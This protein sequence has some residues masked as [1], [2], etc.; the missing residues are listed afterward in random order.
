[1]VRRLLASV[2][3][4]ALSVALLASNEAA[5]ANACKKDC[6]TKRKQAFSE[7]N[8]TKKACIAAAP[9]GKAGKQQRRDCKVAWRAAKKTAKQ[10]FNPKT[11]GCKGNP[12]GTCGGTTTTTIPAPTTCT[13]TPGN[14]VELDFTV[15][16]TGSD[17]D[18]GYTGNSHNFPVVHGSTLSYCLSNC[19]ASADSTC[20]AAGATGAGTPNTAFFG[21]PLPLLSAGVPVCV[22][23]EFVD[24]TVTGTVDLATGVMSTDVKLTSKVYVRPGNFVTVCP[25]CS[26]DGTLGSTGKCQ[27][28]SNDGKACKVNGLV[29][30]SGSN[31][32]DYQVSSD[33]PPEGTGIPLSIDLPLTTDTSQKT[34]SLP[35][36]AEVGQSQDDSCAPG[37]TCSVD[38]S[39]IQDSKGGL[40]QLCCTNPANRPCFPTKS[41]PGIVRMGNPSIPQPAWPDPTYP[42]TTPAG[43]DSKMVATFCIP[44]TNDATV[45]GLTGLPGPG[46]IILPG[47]VTVKSAQ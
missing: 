29:T 33:C 18:N 19:D 21:A 16:A 15:P 5:A 30:V 24:P 41:G 37:A 44:K 13:G 9:K 20:D 2:P 39:G 31:P 6:N 47:E 3:V 32:P 11:A 17:L 14:P 35:C 42:K 27:G 10:Q 1:M 40:N 23:N 45:D 38:C 36:K 12:T 34:G 28:G 4:I 43:Q 46:A 7:A 8:A 22:V 26:G 25:R